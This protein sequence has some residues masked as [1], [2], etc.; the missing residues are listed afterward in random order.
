M[1][2]VFIHIPIGII[3]ALLSIVDSLLPISFTLLFILY[4]IN[5]DRHLGDCAYKDIQGSLIGL[6]VGGLILMLI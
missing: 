5:E 3:I 4:E 6:A 1:K 2:R